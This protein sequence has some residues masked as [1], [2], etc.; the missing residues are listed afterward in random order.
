MTTVELY[1]AEAVSAVS[2]SLKLMQMTTVASSIRL[3]LN[4]IFI[5]FNF[6]P[7]WDP[8]ISNRIGTTYIKYIP[9]KTLTF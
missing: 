1:F 3:K 2:L 9:Q 5:L 4:S 6:S 7:L 8:P